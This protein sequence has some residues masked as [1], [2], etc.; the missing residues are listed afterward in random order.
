[1][2]RRSVANVFGSKRL[3][4]SAFGIILEQIRENSVFPLNPGF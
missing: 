3:T 1:M 2:T 4:G